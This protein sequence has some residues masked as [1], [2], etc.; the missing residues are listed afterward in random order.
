[1]FKSISYLKNNNIVK[2]TN[3][4]KKIIK[5]SAFFAIKGSISNGNDYI[6]N[7]IKLGA[8]IIVSSNKKSLNQIKNNK[9]I[10]IY[11][12]DVRDLYSKECSRINNFPSSR[13]DICGITGTNGKTSIATMLRFIWD[14][15]NSGI[16][17]TIENSYKKNVSKSSLTTPDTYELNKIISKMCE[18]KIENLFMEVSSHALH[19]N[20]VSY[21]DFDSA[22]FSN[23]TQDH[24]DYHKNMKNYFM[25]KKKLFSIHLQDS[26]KKNKYA[27][28]N[29]DNPYG[30]K[31]LIQK[32]GNIKYISY[33]TKENNADFFLEKVCKK[34]GYNNLVI[35]NKNKQYLL[36]TPMIGSFNFENILA[37]FAYSITKKKPYQEIYEK[38]KKFKGAKGRLEHVGNRNLKIFIDY[39]HTHDALEK[40]LKAL[41]NHYANKKLILVFGCG[42]NR[43]ILKRKK[44]GRVAEKF[45]DKIILTNDNPRNEEPKKIIKDIINGI[46][47][48]NDLA[49]IT[50]REKAIKYA[51]KKTNKDS[52]LLI[53]GK[54][55]EDYQEIKGE[56]IFFSDH[57]V[58]KKYIKDK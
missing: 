14:K 27:F 8:N 44:M 57:E 40:S 51:I 13:I 16:I 56:K 7:A 11:C 48:I 54:G 47:N 49:T 17:G 18:K 4:T 19:Q 22:I 34:R 3:S 58:V 12:K 53:A 32:K 35:R 25:A 2:I 45:S 9:I 29:L 1:M 6:E 52:V 41:R 5:G 37:C 43:D 20:R 23:I 31:L 10:K 46:N 55:H 30:K 36:D 33:S 24:L 15:N 28:I 50:N 39:A 38:I 42:G 26:R 21:I